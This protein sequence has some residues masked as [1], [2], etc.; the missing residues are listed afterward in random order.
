[1]AQQS[2]TGK[3]MNRWLRYLQIGVLIILLVVAIYFAQSP[4]RVRSSATADLDYSVAQQPLV[5]VVNPTP[6]QQRITVD[7]TGSIRL[8]HRTNVKAEVSSRVVW[9]S[10]KFT[11]GGSIP[12][13]E[14]FL[15]LEQVDFVLAV[16]AAEASVAEAEARVLRQVERGKHDE[17]VFVNRNP[18]L[19]VSPRVLREPS[20]AVEEA[21][22]AKANIALEVAQR[23]LA[24]T[25]ISLPFDGQVI[26]TDIG[27]GELVGPAKP[28][29]IV[30]DKENIRV[31][32]PIEMA[33]LRRLEPIV[34]RVAQVRAD[35]RLFVAKVVNVSS[36]V[37]PRSRMASIFLEFAEDISKDSLPLPGSFAEIFIDGPEFQDVFVLPLAAAQDRNTVWTVEN[38]LLKS[39]EPQ[40]VGRSRSGWIVEAFDTHDGVVLGSVPTAREG[41]A[42]DIAPAG[43]STVGP[44][45]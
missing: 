18:D 41:L 22:L 1:M 2:E 43:A 37:A 34:G 5:N 45:P 38:G 33:N 40:V 21:G 19:Q 31:E 3:H 29:G 10:P 4:N 6:T 8:E 39:T 28:L 17:R 30:Y 26:S 20:I 12:K 25:Q 13:D 24:K 7:L 14:T 35:G 16:E 27:L 11:N 9:I 15:K 44:N 32:A 36:V 23:R 42:V